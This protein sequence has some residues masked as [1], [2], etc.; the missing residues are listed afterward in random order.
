MYDITTAEQWHKFRKEGIGGS[1]AAAIMGLSPYK[2]NQQLC[3]EKRGLVKAKNIDDKPYVI[4]GKKIEQYIRGI[5]SLDFPQ[6]DVF[7]KEFDVCVHPQYP[8]IRA[9]LDGRVIA[10]KRVLEVKKAEIKNGGQMAEWKDQVP[11]NYF[12]QVLHQLLASGY[13]CATLAADLITGEGLKRRH[14]IR[15]YHFERKDYL[16]DLATLLEEEVKFWNT[17]VLPHNVDLMIMPQKLPV[18]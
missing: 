15:Y 16:E 8:F 6:H 9:T 5:Y 14:D 18:I 3:A 11:Y 10:E 17:Y 7:Y 12:I 4:Y 13:E 2:T 1:D